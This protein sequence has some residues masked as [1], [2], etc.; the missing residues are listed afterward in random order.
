MNGGQGRGEGT[1]VKEYRRDT[2][3]RWLGILGVLLVAVAVAVIITAVAFLHRMAADAFAPSPLG[4]PI[5]EKVYVQV[6]GNRVW[7]LGLPTGGSLWVSVS[8]KTYERYAAA[9]ANEPP[10]TPWLRPSGEI[11]RFAYPTEGQPDDA[12]VGLA[13]YSQTF[14]ASEPLCYLFRHWQGES[15]LITVPA[16]VFEQGRGWGEVTPIR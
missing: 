7:F 16:K 3:K 14:A 5:P 8:A 6:V 12:A 4:R 2:L 9:V 1:L 11:L 10:P 13:D 15:F